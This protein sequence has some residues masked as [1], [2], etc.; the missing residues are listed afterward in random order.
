MS[1]RQQLMLD[2]QIVSF[3]TEDSQLFLDTHPTDIEALAYYNYYNELLGSLTS[4]YEEN[5][6]PLT[7]SGVN[8]SNGWTWI[9]APWPWE[10]E[11]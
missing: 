9:D 11:A 3:L 2:I 7:D 10:M 8:T 6:G 5:F 1:E 4:E